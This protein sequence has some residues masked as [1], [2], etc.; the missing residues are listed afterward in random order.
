MKTTIG[1]VL[2]VMVLAGC[3]S[4]QTTQP[5]DVG[6]AQAQRSGFLGDYSQLKPA[7]DRDGVELYIDR[8]VDYTRYTKLLLDPIQVLATPAPG[9]PPPAPD[10]VARMSADFQQSLQ[11]ALAP[12]YQVVTAAGPDVLRVRI[13]ITNL[14][15]VKP[16]TGASDFLP[17]KALYNAGRAA[18]GTSPRLVEMTAEMEALAPDGRRV[19]AATATR[20]GDKTLP[21]GEQITWAELQSVSD[22]WAGNFRTRLDEMRGSG[23]ARASA[24]E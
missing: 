18:A 19:V 7:P 12:T 4:S 16:P 6:T 1:T 3:Q 17:I 15:T 8:S 5:G 2:A 11:R 21:Q 14:Q 24:D 10:A 9:Q 23:T 13:A 22:Y 20:R